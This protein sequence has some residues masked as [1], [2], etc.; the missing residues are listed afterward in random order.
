MFFFF[1]C[2]DGVNVNDGGSLRN[3][4]TNGLH[5]KS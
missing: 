5:F 4:V 3:E 2:V 1:F